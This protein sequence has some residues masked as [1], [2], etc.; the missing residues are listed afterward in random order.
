VH[1]VGSYDINTTVSICETQIYG[2]IKSYMFR[3][4][5]PLSSGFMLQKCTKKDVIHV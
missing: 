1:F 2:N 4:T 5:K 3:F